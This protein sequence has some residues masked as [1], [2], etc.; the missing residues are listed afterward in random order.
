LGPFLLTAAKSRS[1]RDADGRRPISAGT[2]ARLRQRW[3]GGK[4]HTNRAAGSKDGQIN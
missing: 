1:K 3:A 2:E 4:F